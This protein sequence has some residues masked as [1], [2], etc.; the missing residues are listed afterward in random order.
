MFSMEDLNC[1]DCRYYLPVDVFKG[2]CK[3]KKE[4]LTPDDPFCSQG[5]RQPK[6]KF[7]ANY[8]HTRENLGQC[9]DSH[10]AYP[11]MNGQ[12]CESF[13]WRPTR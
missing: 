7:C 3:L 4:N 1:K 13:T 9:M 2:M 10:F 5:E 11:E 12:F 8:Q 6:C